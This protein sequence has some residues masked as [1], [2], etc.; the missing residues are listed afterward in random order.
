MLAAW[1]TDSPCRSCFVIWSIA[2]APSVSTSRRFVIVL[3]VVNDRNATAI[4]DVAT[5]L[6]TAIVTISSTRVNPASPVSP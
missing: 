6:I 4:T 1:S 3:V 5:M 2:V